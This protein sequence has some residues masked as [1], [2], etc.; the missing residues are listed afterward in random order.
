MK[1]TIENVYSTIEGATKKDHARLKAALTTYAPGYRYTKLFKT[2]K[3]DGKARMY[4]PSIGRFPTGMLPAVVNA[5]SRIDEIIDN[6]VISCK[7][8]LERHN[9]PLRPYQD[10]AVETALL[11]ELYGMW[12]PRGV[13]QMATGGG[14]TETAAAMI[15]MTRVP[16]LFLVNRTEL[17]KQ[18]VDRFNKFGIDAGTIKAGK[19]DLTKNVTVSTIQTLMGY[20]HKTNKK[21]PSGIRTDEDVKKIRDRKAERGMTITSFLFSIEQVFIDEAHFIAANMEKGNMFASALDLMPNAYMR[22]GLTATPFMREE[23]HNW[24]LTGTT[25]ELLYQISNRTLIDMG[26]LAEANVTMYTIPKTDGVPNNWPECYDVGI[27]AHR[28]R[29]AQIKKCI[30][31][32]PGPT[33][34]LVKSL[35]HGRILKMQ[36]GLPFVQGSSKGT[37]RNQYLTDFREGKINALIASSIWDE[38]VDIPEI[39][40]LILAAG[41]KGK[42]KNLQRLGRGLRLSEGKDQVNVIDF[43]DQSTRWLTS[44]AKERKK[45]WEGEGF[46]VT[47]K[48]LDK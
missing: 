2:G 25:G 26:Y 37:A 42:I 15:Q 10:E 43:L 35:D 5:V 30:E 38:G 12:W 17:V 28:R 33:L 39:K 24:L 14:K 36:T 41:G 1:I 45:T 21:T 7:A 4:D 19:L 44:H 13:I 31:E 29:N 46:N 23:Y 3:W 11:H 6:R 8:S 47:I 16:T 9:V 48:E 34:V 22:W 40:T 18:A 32:Q 20:K 27:V